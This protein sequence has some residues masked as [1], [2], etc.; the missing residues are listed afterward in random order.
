[1]ASEPPPDPADRAAP[2]GAAVPL[3]IRSPFR[4]LQRLAAKRRGRK[5]SRPSREDPEDLEIQRGSGGSGSASG[6]EQDG[7]TQRSSSQRL[8][9]RLQAAI[10]FGKAPSSFS[11]K[12]RRVLLP[13]EE[14]LVEALRQVGGLPRML[15][16]EA[17]LTRAA[18]GSLKVSRN[19]GERGGEAGE[20]ASPEEAA[21]GLPP[22]TD[23][24]WHC[25]DEDSPSA[26]PSP[27]ATPPE[28]P[29]Q[30]AG[31]GCC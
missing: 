5:R 27:V 11:G 14:P 3:A 8:P 24:A 29:V 25:A 21:Q 20:E 23:E 17:Q 7:G 19:A 13:G 18:D 15:E 28:S 16:A 26:L 12:R 30:S 31:G 2:E 10:A 9:R 4:D 6:T 22:G 1:M